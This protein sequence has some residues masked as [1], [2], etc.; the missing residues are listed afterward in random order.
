MQQVVIF[1]LNLKGLSKALLYDKVLND[2]SN[3]VMIADIPHKIVD[4]YGLCSR[5]CCDT[6]AETSRTFIG[7]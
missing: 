2:G 6:I 4:K 5:T 7:G 1:K 3:C